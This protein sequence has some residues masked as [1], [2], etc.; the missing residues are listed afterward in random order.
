MRI[1]LPFTKY[2]FLQVEYSL[3]R[4]Y[5]CLLTY[6]QTP[7]HNRLRYHVEYEFLYNLQ[8]KGE[9][10]QYRDTATLIHYQGVEPF[11]AQTWA[12]IP[13]FAREW[14]VGEVRTLASIP[15]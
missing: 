15:L 9:V 6:T 5:R 7:R 12:E 10:T 8:R 11:I 1:S 2:R 14:Q 4:G 13:D 3:P